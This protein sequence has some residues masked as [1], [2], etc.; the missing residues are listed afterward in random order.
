M[1]QV[2]SYKF[3]KY[4]PIPYGKNVNFKAILQVVRLS[5]VMRSMMTGF[6][7]ISALWITT[8]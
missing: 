6:I 8:F 7:R 1:N 4:Q 3:D 2:Q 5:T